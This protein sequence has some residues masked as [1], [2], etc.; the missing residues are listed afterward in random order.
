MRQ[1]E[2]LSEATRRLQHQVAG[3]PR[4]L[5]VLWLNATSAVKGFQ[6]RTS[7][8]PSVLLVL[9]AALGAHA[10]FIY[11]P[12]IRGLPEPNES[13]DFLLVLWQVSAAILGIAFVILIFIIETIHRTAQ[14]EFLWQRFSRSSRLYIATGFILATI[15]AIGAGAFLLQPSFGKWPHASPINLVVL[16]SLLFTTALLLV[17]WLYAEVFRLLNPAFVQELAIGSL[18]DAVRD[19]VARTVDLRLADHVLGRQCEALDLQFYRG[20]TDW[21]GMQPVPLER[22]GTVKD[23]NLRELAKLARLLPQQPSP[24]GVL[25]LSISGA[26]SPGRNAALFVREEALTDAV[27]SQAQKCFRVSRRVQKRERSL[28]EAFSFLTEQALMSINAGRLEQLARVLETLREPIRAALDTLEAYGLVLDAETAQ[29]IFSFEWPA[30]D[31]PFREYVR[32]VEAAA[33]S[34]DAEMVT[35]AAGWPYSVARLSMQKRD[36]YFFRQAVHYLPYLYQVSR[37]GASARAKQLLSDRAWRHLKELGSVLAWEIQRTNEVEL[38][39]SAPA[40]AN[41]LHSAFAN[42][43]KAAIDAND[44]PFLDKAAQGLWQTIDINMVAYRLQLSEDT[45]ES[46]F[47][48]ERLNGLDSARAEALRH[49]ADFRNAVCMALGGWVCHRWSGSAL[50]AEFA[51]YCFGLSAQHFGEFRR[52]WRALDSALSLESGDRLPLSDWLMREQPEGVVVSLRPEA[53]VALFFT[54]VALRTVPEGIEERAETLTRL[55]QS[56]W[57]K[58]QVEGALQD[59]RRD[60]GRWEAIAGDLEQLRKEP[61]I[62]ALMDASENA[63]R[64]R[65]RIRMM[66]QP[67]SEAKLA[68]FK[69]D[70]LSAWVRNALFRRLFGDIGALEFS[71]DSPSAARVMAVRTIMPKGPFVEEPGSVHFLGGEGGDFGSAMARGEDTAIYGQLAKRARRHPLGRSS[72]ARKLADMTKRLREDGLRPDAIILSGGYEIL[73]GLES[74]ESFIPSYRLPGEHPPDFRGTF[75]DVPICQHWPP[76]SEILVLSLGGLGGIVQ[77]LGQSD[78]I[79]RL[80]EVKGYSAEEAR[81][82]AA[83]DR[84][85]LPQEVRELGNDEL[86]EYL[87]EHVSVRIEEA[88]YLRLDNNKAARRLVI[89]TEAGDSQ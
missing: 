56:N 74:S 64:R 21:P 34:S 17:L 47:M 55:R 32:I 84:S 7:G 66:E 16:D 72:L 10:A 89:P 75:E 1:Q 4:M 28:D 78:S 52:L 65:E 26:V 45:L 48:L 13:Q 57:A 81:E 82:I 12:E 23:V 40:Y 5:Q 80:F 88:L 25:A 43:L 69:A 20:I 30:F 11:L 51:A 38:L 77:Y 33:R 3:S 68:D 59:I 62:V 36:H 63:E 27:S 70:F 29:N 42:L 49:I 14:G 67:L 35:R 83:G 60:I 76:Q 8:P 85:R 31:R 2:W 24:R 87:R 39:A 46:G 54:L 37:T 15:I 53:L 50:P 73:R 79:F 58:T 6:E 44:K 9:A 22:H 19:S 18:L 61:T 71:Q 41:E 86:V